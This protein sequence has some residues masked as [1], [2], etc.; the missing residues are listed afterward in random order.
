[1]SLHWKNISA[2]GFGAVIGTISRYTLHLVTVNP[3]YPYGTLIVNIVGSGL[4]GF[5]TALF[6]VFV[7]KEWVKAGLG[8][9]FCGGF[10]TMSTLAADAYILFDTFSIFQ[11]ALY[12]IGS[13]I[14]GLLA[15]LCGYLLGNHYSARL[16]KRFEVKRG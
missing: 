4:L 5:I 11:S 2:V 10:T 1:M 8:V 7:P 16:K 12:I 9:G 14:G 15:A 3:N 6:L 13:V